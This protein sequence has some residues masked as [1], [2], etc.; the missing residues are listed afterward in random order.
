MKLTGFS[1]RDCFLVEAD[2]QRAGMSCP[3]VIISGADQ[4]R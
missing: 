3:I 1:F 4:E 2:F